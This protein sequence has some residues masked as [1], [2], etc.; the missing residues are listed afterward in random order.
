VPLQSQ[1]K[2]LE[3]VL[4]SITEVMRLRITLQNV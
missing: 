4:F 1:K 3:R 2:G